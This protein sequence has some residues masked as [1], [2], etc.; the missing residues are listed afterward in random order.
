MSEILVNNVYV[1][2]NSQ[3]SLALT[4]GFEGEGEEALAA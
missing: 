2:K 3:E 4:G 1:F